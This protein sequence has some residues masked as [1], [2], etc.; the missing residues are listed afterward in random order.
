MAEPVVPSSQASMDMGDVEYHSEAESASLFDIGKHGDLYSLEEIND[1]FGRH[2]SVKVTDYFQD[3]DKLIQSVT[4]L[5]KVV[6]FHP[7]PH[8]QHVTALG[9]TVKASK[10]KRLKKVK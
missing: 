7:I 9:K 10:G 4:I 5:Q 2:E 1:F 6:F 3:T 8:I